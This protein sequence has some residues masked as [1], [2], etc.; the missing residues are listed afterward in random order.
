MWRKSLAG[1]EEEPGGRALEVPDIIAQE[2]EIFTRQ[3]NQV[4]GVA[5][6][7]DKPGRY[8]HLNSAL[9]PSIAVSS[10]Q[11]DLG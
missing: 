8:T 11:E 5:E 7:L 9:F 2:S 4:L 3:P 6:G 10:I 1:L